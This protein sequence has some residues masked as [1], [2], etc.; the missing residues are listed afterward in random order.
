MAFWH[1]W[2]ASYKNPILPHFGSCQIFTVS[3]TC[4]LPL[5]NRITSFYFNLLFS[6]HIMESIRENDVAWQLKCPHYICH[7]NLLGCLLWY[8]RSKY[9]VLKFHEERRAIFM[10]HTH[11][12]SCKRFLRSGMVI[13]QHRRVCWHFSRVIRYWWGERQL[14][15]IKLSRNLLLYRYILFM[16]FQQCRNR[17]STKLTCMSKGTN[18]RDGKISTKLPCMSKGTNESDGSFFF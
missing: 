8:F 9:A 1:F 12:N 5:L 3:R 13:W 4:P 16:L 2:Y 10:D 18:E 6:C 7:F 17:I 14:S 11:Y 15:W